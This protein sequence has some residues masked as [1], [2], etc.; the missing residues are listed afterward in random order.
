MR[1]ILFFKLLNGLRW[2]T[3][4]LQLLKHL[5][6]PGVLVVTHSQNLGKGAAVRTGLSHAT[7]DFV[8]IQDADLEYDPSHYPR[9]L[10]PILSGRADVVF[11][12]RF[13][14]Q[15]K[16]MTLIQKIGNLF[17]TLLTNILYGV[18]L[19]DM[20]TCYKVIPL[21]IIQNLNLQSR[22]FEFEPEVTAKLLKRGCRIVE[23]PIPYVARSKN[24]G[25]KINWRHGFPAMKVLLTQ[26]FSPD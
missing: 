8:I 21:R 9:L 12:S 5:R 23:I 6:Q 11:G 13:Q 7:G 2:W 15:I 17:L 22:G 4:R 26:R 25:K 18:C 20:E 1:R 19:T 10:Q 24:E 3:F 16:R 14:G